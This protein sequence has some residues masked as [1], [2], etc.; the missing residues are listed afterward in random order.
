[1]GDGLF[2]FAGG[3][4]VRREPGGPGNVGWTAFSIQRRTAESVPIPTRRRLL[5]IGRRT[6]F[7]VGKRRQRQGTAALDLDRL[8]PGGEGRAAEVRTGI[9]ELHRDRLL[10]ILH[11]FDPSPNLK[12]LFNSNTARETQPRK[13][14][15]HPASRPRRG[16]DSRSPSPGLFPAG[17]EEKIKKVGILSN[18]RPEPRSKAGK[19]FAPGNQWP[20]KRTL[21]RARNPEARYRHLPVLG[22]RQTVVKVNLL[23][24]CSV[25]DAIQK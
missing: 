14:S 11:L 2:F 8:T 24:R 19:A 22:N 9:D 17:E 4:V 18:Q 7:S 13:G 10:R 21:F 3:G 6:L 16:R 12:S 25:I 23:R 15:P 20:A 1:M 5:M